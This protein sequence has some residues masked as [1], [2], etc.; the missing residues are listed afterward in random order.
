[1]I[2]PW[3]KKDADVK[4][5]KQ[6]DIIFA[7][8]TALEKELLTV[9]SADIYIRAAG[10]LIGSMAGKELIPDHALALSGIVNPELVTVTLK[11]EAA[12]QYLRKEEVKTSLISKGWAVV[13]YEGTNLGWIKILSNRSN[14]YYPKEWRI[15]KSGNQ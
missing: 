3:L 1:L 10:V 11:K 2:R 12:L 15:L 4:L 6:G 13:Q 9:V 14:N 5:W 7:F 8:P